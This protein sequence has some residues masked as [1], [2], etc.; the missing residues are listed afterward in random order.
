[1]KQSNVYVLETSG[2]KE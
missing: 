2:R 1:M